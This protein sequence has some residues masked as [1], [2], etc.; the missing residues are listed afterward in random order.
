MCLRNITNIFLRIELAALRRQLMLGCSIARSIDEYHHL[1]VINRPGCAVRSV[2]RLL[3]VMA[4]KKGE[5]SQHAV[6]N[7]L[8]AIR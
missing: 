4:K 3:T 1:T 7:Q 5:A 6:I 8:I 2:E